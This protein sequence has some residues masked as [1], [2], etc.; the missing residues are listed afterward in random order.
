MGCFVATATYGSPLESHVSILKDFRDSYLVHC[1]IGRMI[2]RTYYKYSPDL[3]LFIEKHEF[4]KSLT[5]L[6]L[7]PVIAFSY[8]ALHFGILMTAVIL[9][10]VFLL[11]TVLMA[12]LFRRTTSYG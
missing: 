8:L 12:V 7:I 3:A 2:V 6:S 1:S 5:A 4:L 11:S 9:I 10:V